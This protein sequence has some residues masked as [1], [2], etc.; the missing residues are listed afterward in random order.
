MANFRKNG[1]K[2]KEKKQTSK[3]DTTTFKGQG[4]SSKVIKCL[5]IVLLIFGGMYLVT[6]MILNHSDSSNDFTQQ[7]KTE[8]QYDEILLGTTFKMKD[9]E[10]LV[11]FYDKG[12]DS[13]NTYGDFLSNY[14]A[15]EEKLPIYHV[16]LGNVMNRSCLSDESNRSATNAKE[17]RINDATLIRLKNHKIEEY[18]VGQEEISKFFNQ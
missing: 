8:I 16:D 13:E 17:L 3:I 4:D 7:E 5:I 1:N 18:L 15:K 12:L 14:E 6:T 11:L 9:Q 2:K 10:Y